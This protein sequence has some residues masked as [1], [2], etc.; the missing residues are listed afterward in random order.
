MRIIRRGEYF[1]LQHSFRECGKVVTREK[2][3]GKRIPENVEGLKQLSREE[4]QRALYLKLER[5]KDK[6]Q[7]EWKRCPESAKARDIQEIAIAFTYNTN[8][9]EGS[10]ITLEETR[11]I[12]VDKMASNK[13]LRDVRE[14]EAHFDVFL[15]MLDKQE[16]VSNELVLR[17]HE[18]IFGGTKKDIAG[19]FRDFL[20][21]VGSYNAP[22]WQDVSGLMEELVGFIDKGGMNPVELA[23]RAHYRFEKIHPFGDGNGRIGRLLMNHILWHG[24]YPMLI[25]EYAKRKSYYRALLRD[26]DGFL[27]YFL[28]RYLA[29]HGKRY[30]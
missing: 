16:K 26:E 18:G 17:W 7:E 3:L 1:Y 20:V 28:R 13:P 29:V 19:R 25:I 8:A 14:T 27:N 22:D 23:A 9:I 4:W 15:E 10:T 30:G 6:F 5:I 24:G 2:Y 12:V 21:R 11:G